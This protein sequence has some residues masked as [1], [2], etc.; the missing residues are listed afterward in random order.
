[1]IWMLGWLRTTGG[2]D[3]GDNDSLS[4]E[5]WEGDLKQCWWADDGIVGG[6]GDDG[7]FVGLEEVTGESWGWDE[8]NSLIL[9]SNWS[10]MAAD[11]VH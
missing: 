5:E 10:V 6:D 8:I 4:I 2:D 1:M 11:D 7:D 9:Q 3:G